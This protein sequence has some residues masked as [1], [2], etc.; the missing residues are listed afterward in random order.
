MIAP[1]AVG[2]EDYWAADVQGEKEDCE[3]TCNALRQAASQILGLCPPS[4][5]Y[6]C[7][8]GVGS[9]GTQSRL[10]MKR[11]MSPSQSAP[12]ILSGS[13]AR[14]VGPHALLASETNMPSVWQQF[15]C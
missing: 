9:V 10:T 7:G 12:K 3:E 1:Q 2:W 4:A 14:E 6:S 13:P 15:L 11:A 5:A 8:S